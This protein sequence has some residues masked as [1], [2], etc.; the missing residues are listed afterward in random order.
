MVKRKTHLQL[1]IS[2][3]HMPIS[4][5]KNLK[6][7][8]RL[9]RIQNRVPDTSA[10]CTTTILVGNI[11]EASYFYIK[12]FLYTL[13]EYSNVFVTKIEYP[14]SLVRMIALIY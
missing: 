2:T 3:N 10:F 11:M 13:V 6:P 14:I 1:K 4:S 7:V 8:F 5:I 12:N 9:Y